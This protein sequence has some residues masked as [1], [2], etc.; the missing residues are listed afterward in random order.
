MCKSYCAKCDE[1]TMNQAFKNN[2]CCEKCKTKILFQCSTCDT[3]FERYS[4]IKYHVRNSCGTEMNTECPKCK[5][6]LRNLG[7][8]KGHLQ[9]C[10]R[11]PH[12]SCRL[13]PYKTKFK[14]VLKKHLEAHEAHNTTMKADNSLIDE[15]QVESEY[16]L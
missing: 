5:K 8:L 16:I 7:T 14:K 10:R 9:F 3:R 1:V 4:Q 13:C 11:E 6:K 15:V 12:I 2:P